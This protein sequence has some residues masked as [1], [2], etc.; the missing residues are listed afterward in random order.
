MLGKKTVV[1]GEMRC[2]IRHSV[3]SVGLDVDLERDLVV[4]DEAPLWI[5][6]VLK[7]RTTG[8]QLLVEKK[9]KDY[10]QL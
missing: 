7:G 3:R 2:H 4:V 9:K 10:F 1:D 6:H 5:G 8:T